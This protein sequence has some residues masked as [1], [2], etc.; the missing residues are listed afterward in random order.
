M[1]SVGGKKLRSDGSKCHHIWK[2]FEKLQVGTTQYQK[3]RGV[4]HNITLTVTVEIMFWY[5]VAS[6]YM[7]KQWNFRSIQDFRFR[8]SMRTKC[9]T[10]SSNRFLLYFI[11]MTYLFDLFYVM[12]H[13]FGVYMAV[14]LLKLVV[15][16]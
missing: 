8:C 7:F 14:N 2:V 6:P 10:F 13:Q 16:K 1:D 9:S 15:F 12:Y 11:G 3:R 5:E 4:G